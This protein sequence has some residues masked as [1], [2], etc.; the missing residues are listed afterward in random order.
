MGVLFIAKRSM[1]V[2]LS[3]Y[4]R[5]W[6]TISPSIGT[7]CESDHGRSRMSPMHVAHQSPNAVSFV[8]GHI[9]QS[10]CHE[11]D[12]HAICSFIEPNDEQ[13]K[14]K[15][16]ATRLPT[17]APLEPEIF[18]ICAVD[19]YR[20]VTRYRVVVFTRRSR[21]SVRSRNRRRL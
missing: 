4:R 5:G 7:Q 13:S 21:V 1:R 11:A 16:G 8:V 3:R 14:K 15:A 17:L 19:V 18:L 20:L 12:A 6:D 10:V 2:Q 9:S